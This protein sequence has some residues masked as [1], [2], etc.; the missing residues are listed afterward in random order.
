MSEH[1]QKHFRFFLP[2]NFDVARLR[3]CISRS[4]AD[5]H[6]HTTEKV[7]GGLLKIISILRSSIFSY[8]RTPVNNLTV[9]RK[10]KQ[11]K[12]LTVNYFLRE[13]LCNFILKI[14]YI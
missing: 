7:N 3:L 4:I 6:Y 2:L 8:I 9:R 10:H 5:Q 14:S 1:F 13:L 12:Q 11:L